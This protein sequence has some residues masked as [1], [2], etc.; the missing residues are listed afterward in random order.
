MRRT[1]ALIVTALGLTTL[2]AFAPESSGATFTAS[3]RSSAQFAAADSV[4]FTMTGLVWWLDASRSSTVFSDTACTIPAPSLTEVKCW[5]DA[6]PTEQAVTAPSAGPMRT[7]TING[8]SS[9][10]FKPNQRLAGVDRLG[11]SNSALT[12]FAVLRE[13]QASN[14]EFLSLNGT[15]T[16]GTRVSLH[17]PWSSRVWF[18]DAGDTGNNRSQSATGVTPVGAVTLLTAWK[19]V[20]GGHNGFRLNRGTTYLSNSSTPAITT[21]GLS[22]GTQSA[23]MIVNDRDVAELLVYD[24]YLSSTDITAVETYLRTKWGTP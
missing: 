5:H 19:D 3:G 20:A 12:V 7:T 24:R 11:G 1:F 10:D 23:G 4:P 2:A 17:T 9:L 22:I 18:W 6:R 16:T 14:D 15:D 13:N 8:R 21:G